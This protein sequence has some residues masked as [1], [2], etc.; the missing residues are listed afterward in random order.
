MATD[1][2][3]RQQEGRQQPPHG[4]HENESRVMPTD[5]VAEQ[6]MSHV[7]L[8]STRRPQHLGAGIASGLKNIARG[9]AAGAASLVAMPV[10]GYKQEGAVGAAKGVG[11]GIVSCAAL[12]LAGAATGVVQIVRGAV[13]TPEAVMENVSSEKLWHPDQRVWVEVQLA[14]M[15]EGIPRDDSDLVAAARSRKLQQQQAAGGGDDAEANAMHDGAVR[16][17]LSEPGYYEVLG[18]ARTATQ[19][20]IRKAYAK[21]A[22]KHHPDKNVGDASASE[23]FK[24]VGEAYR[25]LSNELTR[26]EY[27]RTG[28]RADAGDEAQQRATQM[29]GLV[30][31]PIQE[32]LGGEAFLPYIGHLYLATVYFNDQFQFTEEELKQWQERRCLRIASH[33]AAMLGRFEELQRSEGANALEELFERRSEDLI[34]ATSGRELCVLLANRMHLT[35]ARYKSIA[36]RNLLGRS[37]ATFEEWRQSAVS[38]GSTASTAYH[39]L[40]VLQAHKQLSSDD[41]APMLLRLASSDITATVDLACDFVLHDHSVTKDVRW[42]RANNL[43]RFADH[44]EKRATREAPALVTG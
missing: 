34:V 9:V 20:E 13:N 44:L 41:V 32:L 4:S 24:S 38:M 33:L 28:K 3:V 16:S 27:D 42:E 29:P 36:D 11:I 30:I 10:V 1:E 40:R 23:R 35:A 17:P 18:V 31:H 21:M 37:A 15:S 8:F 14:T 39:T 6:A 22:L 25:V 19:S 7:T 43:L 5:S 26:A 2:P 12:S